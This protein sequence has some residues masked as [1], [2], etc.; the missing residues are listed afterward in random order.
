MSLRVRSVEAPRE[1]ARA[2]DVFRD[3]FGE[4]VPA[5]IDVRATLLAGGLCL[6]ADVDEEI[7]GALWGFAGH[8]E[9]GPFQ[10]SHM[11]GVRAAFRGRGVGEALKRFQARECAARGIGRITWTFDPLMAGNARFNLMRLGAVGDAYLPDCYGPMSGVLDPVS[12]LGIEL[13]S[14]RMHVTWR[15]HEPRS[16]VDVVDRVVVSAVT[17]SNAADA[18]AELSRR[19]RD[20]FER[21]LVAVSVEAV[22]SSASSPA[23]FAYGF[24]RVAPRA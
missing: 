18:L 16:A 3:V 23:S 19:C 20:C 12:R 13:P 4:P 2:C 9:L 6:I 22:E 5:V 15:P 17:A 1:I 14:D 21:G 11:T 7:A 10:H 8:D 24:G